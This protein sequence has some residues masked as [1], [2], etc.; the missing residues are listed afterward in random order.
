M[1]NSNSIN[2]ISESEIEEETRQ[3]NIG[4]FDLFEDINKYCLT[5]SD[6][7]KDLLL[8]TKDNRTLAIFLENSLKKLPLS[9]LKNLNSKLSYNVYIKKNLNK[10][11]NTSSLKITKELIDVAKK[12]EKGNVDIQL[13]NV[14]LT[15][16]YYLPKKNEHYKNKNFAKKENT[17][18]KHNFKDVRYERKNHKM[19]GGDITDINDNEYENNN[20]YDSENERFSDYDS[21][22][23]EE[24]NEN[25]N[26]NED[27][28]ENENEE[29]EEDEDE[30]DE[31]DEDEED[32]EDEDEEDEEDEDEEDEEKNEED[33]KNKK[34][35]EMFN[36]IFLET[37]NSSGDESETEHRN[38]R[39]PKNRNP[40][41]Q[42]PKN[43]Q[44]KN[45][46][47]RDRQPRNQQPKNQQPKNQQPKNQQSKNQQP[48]EQQP[49]N[50]QPRDQQPREQQPREQQ[51]K[52][53]PSRNENEV[54]TNNSFFRDC[55][56]N[57]N[58]CLMNKNEICK[59]L[60]W[61]LSVK[62]NI[63]S[64]ILLTIPKYNLDTKKI[65]HHS[66]CSLRL[67]N[68]ENSKFCIPKHLRDSKLPPKELLNEL[69]KYIH[70]NK[71]ACDDYWVLSNVNKTKIHKSQT[72][73]SKLYL[74]RAKKLQELYN[75]TLHEL[76][77]ILKIL[78]EEEVFNNEQLYQIAIQTKELLDKLY[79]NCEREYAL[80]ILTLIYNN[81]SNNESLS[82]DTKREILRFIKL[83]T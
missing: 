48:R 82:A 35:V 52:N 63:I 47:P 34:N 65:T 60:A 67:F 11:V 3:Y 16:Y 73:M 32:E 45:Q 23:D 20:E 37:D 44:S 26:D 24:N 66:F 17:R 12:I 29:H 69:R 38:N 15:K 58:D 14:H 56:P 83:N 42:Q 1:G 30:E 74:E 31:E 19:T 22:E 54:I 4:I 68:I 49:K 36:K 80:L 9:K 5:L 6:K 59:A 76:L 27:N 41:N 21:S 50:Q 71:R 75:N 62:M 7:Y 18:K 72:E 61:H 43:Q 2:N 55:S 33:E 46:Q 70:R 78:T 81:S 57:S 39:Q 79:T 10:K 13:E 40:R 8:S 25:D 51:P 77:N 28:N 64:A 53:Q